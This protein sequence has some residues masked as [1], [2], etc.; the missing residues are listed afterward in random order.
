MLLIFVVF[1]AVRTDGVFRIAAER[2]A[3]GYGHRIWP[4]SEK[5]EDRWWILRQKKKKIVIQKFNCFESRLSFFK[6]LFR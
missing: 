1:F 3:R 5:M 6:N 2:L 4:S